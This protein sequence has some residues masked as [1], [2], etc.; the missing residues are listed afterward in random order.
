VPTGAAPNSV[1]A[2]IGT[3]QVRQLIWQNQTL[4]GFPYPAL[5]T[6]Q[7]AASLPEFLD[8]I[9]KNAIRILADHTYP[10]SQAAEAHEMLLSR[11]SVGKIVLIP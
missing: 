9:E 5:A 10:L 6:E 2:A 4:T 7:I 3:E 1:C 8:L 11:K